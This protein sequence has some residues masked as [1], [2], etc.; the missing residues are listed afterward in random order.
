VR[1]LW[2][3]R[4]NLEEWYDVL[5]VWRGWADDVGGRSIDSGHYVP[6]EAPEE[7][8]SEIRAFFGEGGRR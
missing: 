8:L 2:G 7:T 5:E 4:G 1:V 6:E 3:S